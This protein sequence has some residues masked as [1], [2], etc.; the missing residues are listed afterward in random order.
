MQ[1]RSRPSTWFPT[2]ETQ[3]NAKNDGV[4]S[5]ILNVLE[6]QEKTPQFSVIDFHL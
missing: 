1:L 2:E 5:L 3:I 6:L 4:I